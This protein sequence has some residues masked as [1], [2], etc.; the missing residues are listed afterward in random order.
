[1]RFDVSSLLFAL[2][3]VFQLVMVRVVAGELTADGRAADSVPK[4]GVLEYLGI[5]SAV[6]FIQLAEGLRPVKTR[7]YFTREGKFLRAIWLF[8]L[9][10]SKKVVIKMRQDDSYE[11]ED[12]FYIN[13]EAR[14]LTRDG[15]FFK[16]ISPLKDAPLGLFMF[17]AST[18]LLKTKSRQYFVID[19]LPPGASGIAASYSHYVLVDITDSAKPKMYALAEQTCGDV[20]YDMDNDGYLDFLVCERDVTGGSDVERFTI[21]SLKDGHVIP[22]RGKDH[23]AVAVK[24]PLARE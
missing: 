22:L 5:S 7:E 3:L 24:T 16:D 21:Y 19:G 12:V 9:L 17:H 8:D 11:K 14:L 2:L 20:F 18:A 4:D 6:E 10:K 15:V 13:G 23:V 1:M